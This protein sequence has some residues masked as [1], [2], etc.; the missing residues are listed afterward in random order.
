MKLLYLDRI[1]PKEVEVIRKKNQIEN[2]EAVNNDASTQYENDDLANSFLIDEEMIDYETRNEETYTEEIV[3]DTD[4]LKRYE[5][6]S[7]YKVSEKYARTNIEEK[8]PYLAIKDSDGKINSLYLS[9]PKMYDDNKEKLHGR[10]IGFIN[11]SK[12]NKKRKLKKKDKYIGITTNNI[13]I[14]KKKG[15]NKKKIGYIGISEYREDEENFVEVITDSY[16]WLLTLFIL[17]I[18]L[19]SIIGYGFL[20]NWHFNF[21]NLTLYKTKDIVSQ[22]EETFNISMNTL[23]IYRDGK[24]YIDMKYN[25]DTEIW[26]N[27]IIRNKDNTII[28]NSKHDS[29]SIK[30]Y[31]EIDPK[32]MIDNET[33]YSE[34]ETYKNN[35][36]LGSIK[37]DFTVQVDTTSNVEIT[38]KIEKSYIQEYRENYS[39]RLKDAYYYNLLYGNDKINYTTLLLKA[40]NCETENFTLLESDSYNIGDIYCFVNYDF[41][42]IHY[43]DNIVEHHY[44]YSNNSE[45]ICYQFDYNVADTNELMEHDK[46]IDEYCNRIM[47]TI[48]K[49]SNDYEKELQL[50]EYVTST[51]NYDIEAPYNQS[52]YSATLGRTVCAGYTKMFKYLLDI[53]GIKSFAQIGKSKDQL[54]MIDIYN[55]QDLDLTRHAWNV[56]NIEGDWYICDC[57]DVIY[58]GSEINQNDYYSDYMQDQIKY[59]RFN[60]NS[61]NYRFVSMYDDFKAYGKNYNYFNLNNRQV[62]NIDKSRLEELTNNFT[63][64]N[65]N[66]YEVIVKVTGEKSPEDLKYDII[67]ILGDIDKKGLF[68]IDDYQYDSFLRIRYIDN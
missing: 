16:K 57:T 61:S 60:V 30:E 25:E 26:F 54:E 4:D 66:E 27:L 62:E 24:L 9:K 52:M 59:I 12:T 65:K 3:Y 43:I 21:K 50:F 36:Y 20:N 33:Y 64:T 23:P 15:I 34:F 44:Y 67:D 38:S 45:K 56:V 42:E 49:N 47:N 31:I 22:E 63:Y 68:I 29:N 17:F 6:S 51:N 8:R 11:A 55:P 7:K 18:I 19:C 53:N 28:Y 32:Y 1:I 46:E 41:P 5:L 2:N 37:T 10:R 58:R 39:N 48:D 40:I 35:K 13:P 14:I